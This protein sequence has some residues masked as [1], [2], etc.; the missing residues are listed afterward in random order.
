ML[1][2]SCLIRC[3]TL[4]CANDGFLSKI[5]GEDAVQV[6]SRMMMRSGLGL[7][8]LLFFCTGQISASPRD[9]SNLKRGQ[10]LG[11]L[12]LSHLFSDSDGA[13]RVAQFVH[14][15]TGAPVYFIQADTVPQM[16]TWVS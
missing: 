14:L 16:F 11:D 3:S 10:K 2:F 4:S 12:Q 15:P 6:F 5:K 13:I 9:L 1:R 8:L 7:F